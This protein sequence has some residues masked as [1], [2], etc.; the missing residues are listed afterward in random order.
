MFELGVGCKPAHKNHFVEHRHTLF[1]DHDGTHYAFCDVVNTGEL[2]DEI[3][4]ALELNESVV[5]FCHVVDGV[6]KTAL[7]PVSNILD[8]TVLSDESLELLND[9]GDLLLPVCNIDNENSRVFACE[10]WHFFYLLVDFC[11]APPGQERIWALFAHNKNIIH[12]VFSFVKLF[13]IKNRAEARLSF[14][15]NYSSTYP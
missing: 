4:S 9:S 12:G 15:L 7:A 1:C 3:G 14:F 8:C 13:L 5:A 6:C 2:F 11:P 10:F